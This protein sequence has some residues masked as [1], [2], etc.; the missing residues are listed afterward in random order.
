M[1]SEFILA[2][3][4]PL[5]DGRGILVVG[6]LTGMCFLC[7]FQTLVPIL[8]TFRN[9]K[10]LYFRSVLVSLFGTILYCIGNALFF[11]VFGYSKPVVYICT[12]GLG[13]LIAV[14]AELLL[15][16][17]RLYI[18]SFSRRTL[19]IVLFTIIIY[20]LVVTVPNAI[21][22]FISLLSPSLPL[23]QYVSSIFQ[24]L[25]VIA[26]L[27]INLVLSGIYVG[28]IIGRWGSD[29]NPRAKFTSKLLVL[30]YICL[31]FLDGTNAGLEW[32]GEIAVQTCWLV[33]KLIE[34]SP[35]AL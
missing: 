17:S 15:L 7:I 21:T 12:A 31:V 32:G 29:S 5:P 11:F 24:R 27:L 16:Y 6:A 19:H 2:P 25:E 20:Y 1:G 22:T 23:V 26:Y 4:I 28:R 33:S 9:R 30:A 34:Q 13:Y 10:T 8:T 35:H 18:L 3:N 14:P